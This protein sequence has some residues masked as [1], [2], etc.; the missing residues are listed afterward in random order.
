MENELNVNPWLKIWTSP[1]ETI[2]AIIQYNPSYRL[3]LLY[4]VYG[5]PLL[6]QMA[7]NFSLGERASLM[8]IFGGA[9]VLAMLVGAVGIN[10]GSAL[11]YWTGK[12]I[13]GVGS[14]REVRAAVAWSSVPSIVNSGLWLILLGVF[15]GYLFTH[16]FLAAQFVG[17]QMAVI[18]VATVMQLALAIWGFVILLQT[19]GEAQ[20]FSAWKALLNVLLP[21]IVVFIGFRFITWLFLLF[22]GTMH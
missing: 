14:Y 18:F 19:I 7:Q 13:G 2:R 16:Q 10:L 21:I 17:V 20:R 8:G 6:L 4:W 1:R 15:K 11:F 9:L 22:T 3:I 12:W 5:F